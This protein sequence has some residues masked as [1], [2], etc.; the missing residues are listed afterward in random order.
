MLCAG[1]DIHKHV[2]QA[3][4]LDAES[5]VASEDRFEATPLEL[6]SWVHRRLAGEQ[7]VVAIEATTGWRWV[8]RELCA[9]GIDVRLAE[10]VQTRALRGRRRG[11][12]TDR[13]DAR[14]LALLLSREMLPES[15]A[16][17]EEIQRLR[18]LTRLRHALAED[19]TRWAQRLHAFLVQEGWA[20]QRGRLLTAIGR[21]WVRALVLE[22]AASRH[23]E[24]LLGVIEAL[25]AEISEV[26]GEVRRFARSDPRTV[27][28][29]TLYGIG[30]I[31]ACT[32]LAEIGNAT[33]FRRSAQ[34]VRLAGLDPVVE[35][36]ADNRRRGHL[37]KAGSPH[38]RWA[39]VEAAMQAGRPSHVD[40]ELLMQISRRA[41]RTHARL[42]VAR[43]IGRR[44]FHVLREA[45]LAQAA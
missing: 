3:V 38:L 25:D 43:K 42:S 22:P 30:P 1:I 29:Q 45:E 44:A 9:L 27:A 32:L 33:R 19:R 14:W 8:H 10:P 21:R 24:R 15:W 23:A 4:V 6:A 37:A 11:A 28:L 5:G 39:L 36:S 17:P 13:L 20:C 12:K 35:E 16:P 40:H 26:E 2:F 31:I 18:D 34:V 7:C 41:D